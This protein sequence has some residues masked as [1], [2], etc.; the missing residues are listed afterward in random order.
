ML[1]LTTQEL[2]SLTG[3]TQP[4]AQIRWLKT[5]D[6][7]YEIGGDCLPKVASAYFERR[8]VLGADAKTTMQQ[9]SAANDWHVNTEAL[10]QN[11]KN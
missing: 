3:R 11:S 6:W 10:R 2:S 8:M 4:A 7:I 5:R 9:L 1:T